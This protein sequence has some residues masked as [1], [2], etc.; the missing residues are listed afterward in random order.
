M[1]RGYA[2]WFGRKMS[3]ASRGCSFHSCD[4]GSSSMRCCKGCI[5]RVLSTY[6]F[7]SENPPSKCA[8]PHCSELPCYGHAAM[9]LLLPPFLLGLLRLLLLQLLLPP[10]VSTFAAPCCYSHATRTLLLLYYLLPTTTS[11]TTT[12]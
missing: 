1:C 12:T 2:P 9:L 3:Q 6:R 10:P 4:D 5:A 11:A 7:S 8:F